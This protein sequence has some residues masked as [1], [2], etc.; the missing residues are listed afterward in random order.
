MS[1]LVPRQSARYLFFCFEASPC[2]DA[3]IAAIPMNDRVTC[4]TVHKSEALN[5]DA[6]VLAGANAE[7]VEIMHGEPIRLS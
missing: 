1:E 6:C 5:L 7:G 4:R 3:L 2:P